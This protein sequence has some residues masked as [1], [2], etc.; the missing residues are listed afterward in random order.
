M[1]K[2][3]LADRAAMQQ[4]FSDWVAY[5]IRYCSLETLIILRET[6]VALDNNGF[7]HGPSSFAAFLLVALGEN[8]VTALPAPSE[9]NELWR[10]G[11]VNGLKACC[12]ALSQASSE[13][14]IAP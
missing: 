8:G 14:R 7:N 10:Q 5:Q 12:A 6:F 9:V 1:D 4:N 2:D 3:L 13:E 11:Y